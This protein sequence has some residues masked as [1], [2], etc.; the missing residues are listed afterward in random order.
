MLDGEP[1][2]LD[3]VLPVS[4]GGTTDAANLRFAHA[5]CNEQRGAW[6]WG[7]SG[8]LEEVVVQLEPAHPS[9]CSRLACRICGAITRGYVDVDGLPTIRLC[10]EHRDWDTVRALLAGFNVPAAV[11]DRVRYVGT[12]QS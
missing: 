9:P 4:L 3:H 6:W 5:S 11:L 2:A 10:A 8:L 7:G 12:E 1:R